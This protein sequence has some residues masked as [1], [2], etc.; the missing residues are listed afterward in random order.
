METSIAMGEFTEAAFLAVCERQNTTPAQVFERAARDTIAAY[1]DHVETGADPG[2][3]RDRER[4][5][6]MFARFLA[7]S[8]ERLRAWPYTDTGEPE[9]FEA[10]ECQA[11]Q[12]GVELAA[13]VEAAEHFEE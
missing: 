10:A 11:K 6:R 12:H 3:I 4:R 2:M 8:G 9:S 13:M 7:E 1:L 5:E